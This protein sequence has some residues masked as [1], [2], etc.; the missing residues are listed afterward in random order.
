MGRLENQRALGGGRGSLF[1]ILQ[2]FVVRWSVGLELSEVLIFKKIKKLN[3][4]G[5]HV[6]FP[7]F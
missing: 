3:K 1:L 2:P 5:F 4:T 6:T 7:D